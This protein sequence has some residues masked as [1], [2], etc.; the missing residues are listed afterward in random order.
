MRAAMAYTRAMPVL[1]QRELVK[2]RSEA[3]ALL[4]QLVRAPLEAAPER[5]MAAVV[6][7]LCGAV[8]K[9]GL[10]PTLVSGPGDGQGATAPAIVSTFGEGPATV[11]LHA[12]YRALPRTDPR[13]FEPWWDGDAFFGR[14]TAD[15]N[16]GIIAL[17]YALRV[18]RD[19][20]SPLLGKVVLVLVP[21]DDDHVAAEA[22]TQL[23]PL[24][25][26]AGRGAAMYTP[27]PTAG[28]IWYANRGLIHVRATVR[29]SAGDDAAAVAADPMTRALPLLQR[30]FDLRYCVSQRETEH[31][32]SPAE[33]R[34]SV[35]LVAV[36]AAGRSTFE[37]GPDSCRFLIERRMNPDESFELEKRDLLAVFDSA[38]ADGVTCEV[39]V[40]D[41]AWPNG[42]FHGMEAFTSI[43]RAVC[44]VLEQVPPA[45]MVTGP[46]DTR[47]YAPLGIPSLAYGPGHPAA[48]T[49]MREFVKMESVL[50]TAAIYAMTI[51]HQIGDPLCDPFL[52]S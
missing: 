35:L 15:M 9:Q 32:V 23:V 3:A 50:A 40:L 21:G 17:L 22:T 2:R 16:G 49:G 52:Y 39:E 31:V 5:A 43:Q 38:R 24:G 26:I 44:K 4:E 42:V 12:R 10:V 37:A 27:A 11:Y 13:Q 34:R 47:F 7:V 29:S 14:N 51:V 1:F 30:L 36:D 8:Q 28:S 25:V 41:E 45:D 46:L 19:H 18:L 6:D 33:F 48:T 20:R